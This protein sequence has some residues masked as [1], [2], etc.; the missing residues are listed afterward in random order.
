MF[1]YCNNAPIGNNDVS[2]QSPFSTLTLADYLYIHTIVQLL[3]AAEYGCYLEV[4]VQSGNKRGFLDLYDAEAGAY[5]EVK[6]YGSRNSWRTKNQMDKY[7]NSKIKDKRFEGTDIYDSKLRK[8]KQP[9]RGEFVYG[10]YDVT[11]YLYKDGLIVYEVEPNASRT[12]AVALASIAIILAATGNVPAA[13]GIGGLVP[14]L[15]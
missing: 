7:D 5:Y 11:Y 12:A 15:V 3:C 13:A 4:Y 10:I 8:G 9:I 6:S 1:A 14:G 2:G